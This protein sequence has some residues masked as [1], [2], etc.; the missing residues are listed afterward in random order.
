MIVRSYFIYLGSI[1]LICKQCNKNDILM[2]K[3]IKEKKYRD[4]IYK[5]NLER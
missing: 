4:L 2:V 5:V 1:D 3:T